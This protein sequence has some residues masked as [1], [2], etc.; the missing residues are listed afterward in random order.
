MWTGSPCETISARTDIQA[1]HGARA[2]LVPDAR[3]RPDPQL[4]FWRCQRVG[5]IEGS[6]L[7]QPERRLV[8]APAA[9]MNRLAPDQD[10]HKLQ[11]P[12][13]SPSRRVLDGRLT[14]VRETCALQ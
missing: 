14:K 9:A 6:L 10:G 13:F 12:F 5:E 11:L 8:A 4:A 1:E 7:E 3:R 2:T